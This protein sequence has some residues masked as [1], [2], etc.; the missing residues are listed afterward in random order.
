M[1]RAQWIAVL[2]YRR[3][4]VVEVYITRNVDEVPAINLD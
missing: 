3:L 1:S 4:Q 2:R